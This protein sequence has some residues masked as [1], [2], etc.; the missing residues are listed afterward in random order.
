MAL[1]DNANTQ[2]SRHVQAELDGTRYAC[3]SL[4]ALTGGTANFIFKGLLTQPLDDGTREIAIKH[5][6]G[7]VA[8]QPGFPLTTDR[9]RVEKGC[10]EALSRL[11]P[12]AHGCLVRTPKLYSF[13]PDTNTQLQECLGGSV[14]VKTYALKH[15]SDGRDESRKPLCREFGQGLGAWLRSFHSWA[16]L[17]EQAG[18]KEVVKSNKTLQRL[19]H[20][21]NY[22][23]LGAR[24]TFEQVEKMAA[25]ELDDFELVQIIHGDFWTGNA[26]LPDQPWT[27]DSPTSVFIIDWEMCQLGVRPLDLGQMIAELYELFLFKG[28]D[29][30]RWLIEGFASGYGYVDDDFAFR[31]AIHVGT[32]L[33]CWGSRVPGWG[34]ESQVQDVVRRGMELI[35]RAWAKDRAWF[36]AG[37]LACLF[38]E[39]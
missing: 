24:A 12:A 21:V 14:D 9:C 25:D 35:Q 4:E 30:G 10:L 17:P 16:R 28:I 37:D 31:T 11:P 32:H 27:K 8:S 1:A 18:F 34:S 36:E 26:I 22:S 6:K 23:Y 38:C 5:G 2:V 13:N 3:S 39:S 20:M 15:F 29:E 19:K 33:V 7:Y